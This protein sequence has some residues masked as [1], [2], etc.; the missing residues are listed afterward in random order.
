MWLVLKYD[1]KNFELLKQDFLKNLD[2]NLELY[3]PKV[4]YQVYQ[5]NTLVTKQSFLLGNYLFCYHEKFSN[6]DTIKILKFSRGLKYILSGFLK[7]QDEIKNFI[8]HCKKYEDKNKFITA[9]FFEIHKDKKYVFKSGP[10]TRMFF[11]I[12]E[13]NRDKFKILMGK[14]ATIIDKN[15]YLIE[16]I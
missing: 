8:N 13:V 16:P 9:N 5:N 2:C 11:E 3:S 14:S 12:I 1:K 6:L 7:A 10:F 4:L 15:K